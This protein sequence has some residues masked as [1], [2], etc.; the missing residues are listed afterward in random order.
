MFDKRRAV[1]AALL[2]MDHH[3]HE[4]LLE[5]YGQVLNNVKLEAKQKVSSF[6][7]CCFSLVFQASSN[8]WNNIKKFTS[9][10]VLF[11]ISAF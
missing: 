8:F 7:I 3:R 2:T 4:V 6:S 11:S 5:I 10:N 9:A 1:V